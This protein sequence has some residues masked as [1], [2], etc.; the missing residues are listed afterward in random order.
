MCARHTQAREGRN[1]RLTEHV[2]RGMGARE[3]DGG[4]P[5]HCLL[6]FSEALNSF[7]LERCLVPHPLCSNCLPGRPS[8]AP[9]C[10][11]NGN[12]DAAP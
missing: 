2:K 1:A 10:F 6:E 11:R 4:F 8:T 12:N 7:H 5:A 9:V 3:G